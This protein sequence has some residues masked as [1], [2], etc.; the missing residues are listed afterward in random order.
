MRICCSFI[1]LIFFQCGWAQTP[2]VSEL[3][4]KLKQQLNNKE[5][6]D[7]LYKLAERQYN[8]NF[9]HG[10]ES[11]RLSLK[12]AEADG[13]KVGVARALTSI[14]KCYYF[15]GDHQRAIEHFEQSLTVNLADEN[16]DYPAETFIRLSIVY[17][18]QGDFD[19]AQWYLKAAEKELIN[20]PSG[21]PLQASYLASHA[22]LLHAKSQHQQALEWLRQSN[23]IRLQ[24][25]DSSAV[26]IAFR[27]IGMV[28][29]DMAQFD[30][31][32]YYYNKAFEIGEKLND[33]ETLSLTHLQRGYTYYLMGNFKASFAD[34]TA[35]TEYMK[36][37]RYLRYYGLLLFRLGEYYG[38]QSDFFTAFDYLFKSL[39]EFNKISAK[40]DIA[41]I[42]NQ[43]AWCY[44]YQKNYETA[45]LKIAES[46]KIAAS[47]G[48]SVIMAMNDNLVG[49]IDF[50]QQRYAE[51]LPALTRALTVRQRYNLLW[52]LS[53]SLFNTALVYAALNQ[54]DKAEEYFIKA[55]AIDLRIGKKSGYVFTSNRLGLHF[56]QK[57]QY[58]KALRYLT[59]ANRVA[60]EINLPLQL[61]TNY[62]HFISLYEAQG[63]EP[64][65]VTYF[66]KYISLRDSLE[67]FQTQGHVAEAEAMHQLKGKVKEIEKIHAENKLMQ[68]EM[69]LKEQELEQ[70][71]QL[72]FVYAVSIIV[73]LMLVTGIFIL[74]REYARA[75]RKLEKQNYEILEQKEELQTQSEELAEFNQQLI[76]LNQ[77]LDQKNEEVESQ[78]Q[79]ILEANTFLENRVE[80]RTQ[81]L[82]K[83]LHELETFFYRTSHDF[84]RPLT[85]YLGLAQVA[86]IS[87]RDK[88]ALELF[89][90]VEENTINFDKMLAKLQ[91]IGS[92]DYHAEVGVIDLNSIIVEC[93]KLF[94]DK[95]TKKEIAVIT[96]LNVKSLTS[97]AFLLKAA[98]TCIIENAV[99][100]SAI[101]NARLEISSTPLDSNVSIKI[102][103]NGQGIRPE[104]QPKIFDM[105]F[106]ANERSTGNGL[107][108]FIAKRAVEKLNGT[109]SLKSVVDKGTTV[110]IS[111]PV[112]HIA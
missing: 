102:I 5:R 38:Q 44:T 95:I 49:Y 27:N 9:E 40:P 80:E 45:M 91:Y 11:A 72:V 89:S 39:E 33:T 61:L 74:L 73:L 35:S 93:T 47:I 8:F 78:A 86:K 85:T 19:S 18:V 109:I 75:K 31:A 1:A 81:S 53:S 88:L 71:K 42:L 112:G 22:L 13:Y 63:N 30:S 41:K 51:A 87:V 90:M 52:S 4:E 62:R 82:N 57:K 92:V 67:K 21:T 25:N 29:N 23:R 46:R 106:R 59:E 94:E 98:L 58:T 26:S 32:L 103:D 100:Y 16:S 48:D 84:R 36:Q 99:D 104:L 76:E 66:K 28:H 107:G 20:K 60:L 69:Q 12:I 17:R 77:E 70:Q 96:D 14:G 37:N 24:I 3:E 101:S 111:L 7:L 2:N 83:A 56:I 68:A 54:P 110:E 97:N 34:Y 55:Q 65:M 10:L 43:I 50:E 108:L 6:S 15:I 105:Y 79:K 64:K